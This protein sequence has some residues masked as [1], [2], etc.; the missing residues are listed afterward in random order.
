MLAVELAA[1]GYGHVHTATCRDLRD[2]MEIGSAISKAEAAE[3]LAAATMWDIDGPQDV[4][5]APCT[6]YLA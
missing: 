2:P 1:K 4:F 6:S 3:D 5:F